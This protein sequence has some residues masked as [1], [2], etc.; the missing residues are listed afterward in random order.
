MQ[1]EMQ[2]EMQLEMHK[3]TVGLATGL[4]H[5]HDFISSPARPRNARWTG[6]YAGRSGWILSC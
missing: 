3:Y 2:R 5:F 6:H 4:S 1:L